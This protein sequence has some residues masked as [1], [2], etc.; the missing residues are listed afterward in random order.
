MDGA[1]FFVCE[2]CS[3]VFLDPKK[4]L[5]LEQEKL[6]YDIHENND[7]P[8]YRNFLLRLVDFTLPHLTPEMKGLDYGCGPVKL[9]EQIFREKNIS[10]SSYDPYFHPEKALLAAQ[11]DFITCS[12]VVEHF[13]SPPEEFARIFSLLKP[14]G[15]LA[16][17]TSFLPEDK[18]LF[19][20]WYYH[21]DPTHVSFYSPAAL[22][23]LAQINKARVWWKKPSLAI[24]QK[25]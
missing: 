21:R 8:G 22:E 4:K 3:F 6:R 15:Y 11:Y 12:E 17:M 5:T 7:T 16:I 14:G 10:L 2:N 24:F 1:P 20:Q 13:F 18:S 23:Y 9:L 19:D 25:Q